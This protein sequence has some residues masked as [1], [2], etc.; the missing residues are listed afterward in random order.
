MKN[1]SNIDNDGMYQQFLEENYFK[2][3][4][5]FIK[6]IDGGPGVKKLVNLEDIA[7]FLE[8]YG[9]RQANNSDFK[10]N[11]SKINF[12]EDQEK[13]LKIT[14]KYYLDDILLFKETLK[15]AQKIN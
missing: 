14:E 12:F 13:I 6:G 11:Q 15:N 2:P 4:A 7:S 5:N 1:V 3:Q 10:K 8:S 9:C